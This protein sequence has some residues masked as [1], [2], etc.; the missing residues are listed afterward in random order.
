MAKK[1][2]GNSNGFIQTPG[3][4]ATPVQ[5]FTSDAGLSTPPVPGEYG[6]HGDGAFPDGGKPGGNAAA[7]NAYFRKGG[8]K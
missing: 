6:P 8:K 5:Q 1:S 3:G 4:I 2:K 7:L